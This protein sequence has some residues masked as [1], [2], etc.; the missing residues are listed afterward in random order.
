MYKFSF[1]Y[2]KYDENMTSRD[3]R[4]I[5]HN[6]AYDLLK[7]ML[8]EHFNIENEPILKTENGK[9]YIKKDG[10]HFSISHTKGLVC[11]AIASFP[12]GID[13]E[14]IK[15]E[16]KERFIKISNRF[17]VKNEF[18]YLKSKNFS[19]IDFYKIWTGK[20]STIKKLGTTMK[21]V[22]NID[23]TE[24]KICYYVENEYIIAINI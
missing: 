6:K 15:E 12:I 3:I 1:E 16:S 18:E 9:P 10:V 8:K 21:D 24:E 4:A 2:I 11:C 19:P 23:V 14:K 20:E 17:F 5:E 13:C 7:R 22:K